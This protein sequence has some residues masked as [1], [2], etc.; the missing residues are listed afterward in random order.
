MEDPHDRLAAMLTRLKLT[1]IRDQLDSLVDEAARK[2]LTIREALAF[3]LEREIARKDERRI[4]A[5]VRQKRIEAASDGHPRIG[6]SEGAPPGLAES[7]Q[8]GINARG[9]VERAEI[10]GA[11]EEELSKDIRDAIQKLV[12]QPFDQQAVPIVC[13]SHSVN[14]DVGHAAT[15]RT[16]EPA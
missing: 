12:G 3:F 10:S 8:L 11:D 14:G 4:D 13:R 16:R 6:S 15:R 9:M 1:A 5:L 2:E 7:G